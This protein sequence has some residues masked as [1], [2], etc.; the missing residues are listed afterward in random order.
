MHQ[1]TGVQQ[2]V[3]TYSSIEVTDYTAGTDVVDDESED[4]DDDDDDAATYEGRS[5]S[6]ATRP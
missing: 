3:N 6:S 5:K 2:A 4:D 1:I